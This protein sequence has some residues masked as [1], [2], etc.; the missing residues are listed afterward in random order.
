ML[1]SFKK[2][3][4][5]LNVRVGFQPHLP[6]QSFTFI[7]RPWFATK[8]LFILQDSLIRVSRRDE[9]RRTLKELGPV[10]VGCVSQRRQSGN[11]QRCYPTPAPATPPEHRSTSFFFPRRGAAVSA[12]PSSSCIC[13]ATPSRTRSSPR[14]A[15]LFR[16]G[17]SKPHRGSFSSHSVP[18][19][20]FQVLLTCLSAFFSTFL[21]STSPLSVFMSY[22]DLGEIYLLFSAEITINGTLKDA[23][24]WGLLLRPTRGY[25]PLCRGFPTN[26]R[27]AQPH[28]PH[29]QKEHRIAV[30][31]VHNPFSFDLCPLRS[32]L[33]GASL[34]FSFPPLNNMLK[35]SG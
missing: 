8:T 2:I 27:S 22:L 34:L 26:L 20:Q 5:P 18:S 3:Y 23:E 17:C 21:R 24:I 19:M 16:P 12:A 28:L 32:P 15:P 35:F 4:F 7:A 25:H 6:S 10:I 33:L 31:S 29:P 14:F 30:C 11:K 1:R 13:I 9:E